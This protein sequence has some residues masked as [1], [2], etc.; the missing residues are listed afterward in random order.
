MLGALF[1]AGAAGIGADDVLVAAQQLV[2]L[3][4]CSE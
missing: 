1:D 3:N 2:D 4:N